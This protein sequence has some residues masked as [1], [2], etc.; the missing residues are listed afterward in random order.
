MT[1]VVSMVPVTMG[2]LDALDN[3]VWEFFVGNPFLTGVAGAVTR[4]GVVPVL[5]PLAAVFGVFVWRRTGSGTEAALPF[6]SVYACAVVISSLKEWTDVPR[7]PREFWLTTAES[8]SF[9]SGHAGNTAAFLTA[10]YL[11]SAR[12]YPSARR[13]VLWGSV[14]AAVVMAWTRLALNVHWLSDVVAGI[15]VGVLVVLV[16][17]R[18]FDGVRSRRASPP[19]THGS[20]AG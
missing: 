5:L 16:V 19:R 1:T 3:S 4:I 20:R 13:R 7:P 12:V 9:P 10:V 17:S 6:V 14:A 8:A 18:V 2:V 11:V 15:L